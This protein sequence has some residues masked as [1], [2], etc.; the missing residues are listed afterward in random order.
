MIYY[1]FQTKCK[2]QKL[3]LE[4]ELT[5]HGS[6]SKKSLV[7]A[8]DAHGCASKERHCFACSKK[9]DPASDCV[10]QVKKF[11][12]IFPKLCFVAGAISNPSNLDCLNCN[13]VSLKNE[14]CKIHKEMDQREPYCNFLYIIREVCYH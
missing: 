5:I 1:F 14:K 13:S 12:E 2:R 8:F 11:D 6:G 10:L 7:V 9:H 3:C 4:C